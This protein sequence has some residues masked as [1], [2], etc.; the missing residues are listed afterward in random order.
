MP[1]IKG[2]ID[3]G[4]Q[5]QK[6]MPDSIQV[7]C[8]FLLANPLL[9]KQ[10]QI[11]EEKDP[12]ITLRDEFWF[13]PLFP[14]PCEATTA[15]VFDRIREMWAQQVNV[16]TFHF[17]SS[18]H[19]FPSYVNGSVRQIEKFWRQEGIEKSALLLSFHGLPLRRITEKGDGYL[20]SCKETYS[21]ICSR[22]TQIPVE[23]VFLSFQSRFGSE[24]WLSPSTQSM[25]EE[26]AQKG[27]ETLYLYAPS[28][29]IDCLETSQE[30]GEELA[31]E[32]NKKWGMK[33]ILIPCLNDDSQWAQEFALDLKKWMGGD[34][35]CRLPVPPLPSE[36]KLTSEGVKM[37]PKDI[38]RNFL[39]LFFILFIDIVGFTLI[40]PLF[41][42]L[43]KYYLEVSANDPLL[44]LIFSWVQAIQNFFPS[45]HHSAMN[46]IVFF[47]GILGAL[48]SVCQFLFAPLWGHLSDRWGRRPIL[49]SSLI[50][51]LVGSFLWIFAGSFTLLV[52][53][54]LLGG[55]MSGNISTAT[56]VV[57]DMTSAKERSKGMAIIGIAFAL[58]F[59]L[60]PALGGIF[61]LWDLPKHF[62]NV[63]GLNPFSGVATF[64]FLLA[65]IN[66]LLLLFLFRE[67]LT[68]EVR[69]AR[70]LELKNNPG[71]AT[72]PQR[73]INPLVLFKPFPF[74]GANKTNI[75][76]FF[77]LSAFAGM[78]FT[79]TFLAAERFGFGPMDN[80]KM[81]V[82]IGFFIV[83]IQGGLVRRKAH[84]WG[85]KRMTLWG[86]GLIIPG[87]IIVALCGSRISLYLGL[88]FLAIGS[89]MVIP[90]ITSL[91][92][93]YTPPEHQGK[94]LGVFRSLGALARVVGPI[95]A[96]LLYGISVSSLPYWIG[97]LF[98]VLPLALVSSLPQIKHEHKD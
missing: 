72:L 27:I 71:A 90:C 34:E 25:G 76:Y 35:S 17:L 74:P 1:L 13:V 54:R 78:E 59:I 22:L 16:P 69:E 82:Y 55:I 2:S 51:I 91:A 85:E 83:L 19:L 7:N 21:L 47:G 75:A 29:L 79:L 12:G 50:G 14:Q 97:A 63:P 33:V 28:F 48:Y 45:S 89:A 81:F 5:L 88:T 73:S 32:L 49:M 87:L 15:S 67:T 36:K 57:A 3:F 4:Q 43:A 46:Q 44:H 93:L 98:M 77:F 8:S 20:Q 80:A 42:T 31:A 40:F 58:G 23:K 96:S 41:P 68:K 60:G 18:F 24:E 52:V 92:S 86:M 26:L 38:K 84:Q 62:P 10:W 30:L 94:V 70:E 95:T 53:A 39:V 9:E 64:S 66:F 61:S 11:L 6:F 65:L 56:A 37:Q